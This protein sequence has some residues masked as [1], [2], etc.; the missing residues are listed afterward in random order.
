MPR[1]QKF[2]VVPNIP[3]NIRPLITIAYNLWWVWNNEAIELFRRLDPDLWRAC[4]HNPVKFLGILPQNVLEAASESE[5]F[6]LHLANVQAMFDRDMTMKTWFKE[7]IKDHEDASI[8]YFS[9]EFGLHES[10]P[11]YSGGLGVLAGDHLKSSSALGIPLCGVGLLYRLGYFHQYLNMDGWQQER[12]PS[13]DVHTRPVKIVTGDD[14]QPIIIDV[15]YPGRSVYARIWKALVGKVELFLLDTNIPQNNLEDRTITDQLYGGDNEM[16]V[17]QEIML[18]IGG[19]RALRA[20]GKH[21]TVFHMNEGHAAFLAIERIATTMQEQNLSFSEAHEFVMASSVFTTHTPVPA[22]NDRFEPEM[23][24]E[25]LSSYYSKL[26]IGREAFL[27]LGREKPTDK[28]ETFCM[29]VLALKTAYSANGVSKLHGEVSRNMWKGLWPTLPESEIPIGSVTNGIHTLS[30]VSD[31]MVRLLNRYLGIGWMDNPTSMNAWK[32]LEGIPDTELWRAR[33]RSRERLVEFARAKLRQQLLSRG[34]PPKEADRANSVLD[35]EALTIGFARRFATYKRANLILGDMRR[36]EQILTDRERPVQMIFAGKAHPKDNMGKEL[37]RQI[38]RLCTDERFR[39]RIV[40]L[41]DYDI[42]IARYMVQGVDIWLNNP[43]RPKEASG[44]SGMKVIPN[45]GI[46]ISILD[47]WWDEAYNRENGWAIGNREIYDDF[48]YQNEVESLYLYNLLEKEVKP[49]FYNRGADGLP[50]E[51]LHYMR[52]SMLSLAPVFNTDR[53]VKEYTEKY[54]VRA[55]KNFNKLIDNNYERPRAISSW[56][57]RILNKWSAVKIVDLAFESA[58]EIPVGSKITVKAFTNLGELSPED[59]TAE[60][61]FGNVDQN[62]D[63]ADGAALPMSFLEKNSDGLC[64]YVGQI[65]CLQ[66]GQYGFT[67]RLMPYNDDAVRKF[68]PAM[69]VVWVSS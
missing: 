28:F 5:S 3:E 15:P 46:N 23:I 16:R 35:S 2:N 55:H 67:V 12:F 9:A 51:W 7:H 65:L 47:G 66:S 57:E 24:D 38:I 34:Y 69:G 26:G 60:L 22:G 39:N 8:A 13:I 54:Y 10:L 14:G 44:T 59:V 31:E 68:D 33:E 50:R 6:L 29:T 62:D 36:L 56:K 42:N 19:V 21:C 64:V 11:I 27:A 18:G 40:F 58:D 63:I 25:Y 53:M 37:I 32:D 48:E 4:G 61:Y 1:I 49:I 41:E 20:I 52:K 17:K 43:I 30:W 45:G